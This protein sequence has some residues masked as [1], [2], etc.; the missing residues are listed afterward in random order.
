[1]ASIIAKDISLVYPMIGSDTRF[2]SRVRKGSVPDGKHVGGR[3]ITEKGKRPGVV[4]V[5]NLSITLRDGDRLGIFGHNGAGKSTLLR[6]LGGIYP[7]TSG[8][9]AING[10]VTGMFSLG[11]G[12]N[13][14]ASGI[15]N[16]KL[17]GM[18]YG[19]RRREVSELIPEIAEFS[20][21]GEYLHMPVK[22]YSAGMIMRL[23]FA[24]ASAFKP[25]I[26]LL[27]EWISSGD[28]SFKEKVDQRL[29]AML[30]TTPIVIIASHNENRLYGWANKV[31]TLR[32]GRVLTEEEAGYIPPPPPKFQPNPEDV[33]A[34]HKAMNFERFEEALDISGK[35]YPFEENPAIH[36]SRRA[37]ILLRMNRQ[38]EAIACF[39]KALEADPNDPK[40]YDQ[41]S[42]VYFVMKEFEKGITMLEKAL[43]L[44][45]GT[46]GQ[47]A[48]LAAAYQK[49]GRPDTID[50][51][52]R[53]IEQETKAYHDALKTEQNTVDSTN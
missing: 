24:T 25:D 15:D 36:Y 9:I 19:L 42:R 45:E 41:L 49:A 22:T 30:E 47:I 33:Q 7:P 44:S 53:R 13:K 27:D 43:I 23:L 29:D 17:K 51:I 26:L 3:I 21:L 31:L 38:D 37:P 2:K 10:K 50:E 46:Q 32:G 35:V 52:A 8:H 16:I 28:V 48:K 4:A 6:M 18:L 14:E 40:I 12:I 11:L 1:M 5:D 39:E 34:L 20:E